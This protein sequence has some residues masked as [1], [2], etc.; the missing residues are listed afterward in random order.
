V[1]RWLKWRVRLQWVVQCN[2]RLTGRPCVAAPATA[3]LCDYR[4]ISIYEGVTAARTRLVSVCRLHAGMFD[5]VVSCA[6]QLITVIYVSSTGGRVNSNGGSF[7][8]VLA[9]VVYDY[10]RLTASDNGVLSLAMRGYRIRMKWVINRLISGFTGDVAAYTDVDRCLQVPVSC[11][12]NEPCICEVPGYLAA[13]L[14]CL[15]LARCLAVE[16][17]TPRKRRWWF[18]FPLWTLRQLYALTDPCKRAGKNLVGCAVASLKCEP[19]RGADRS[20][21]TIQGVTPVPALA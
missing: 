19:P 6:C 14:M 20:G 2:R 9:Q 21:D 13:W 8:V 18:Y 10:A 5:G 11:Y 3:S 17:F 7:R 12:N 4:L 15:F 1:V 16:A